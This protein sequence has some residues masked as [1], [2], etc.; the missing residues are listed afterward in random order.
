M[1]LFGDLGSG[2]CFTVLD[3]TPLNW[4]SDGFNTILE[5]SECAQSTFFNDGGGT[6]D[7]DAAN[8]NDTRYL[9]AND[10]RG[11]LR[12]QCLVRRPPV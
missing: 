5:Y 10:V 2:E 9:A 1:N 8:F 3:D 6:H 11:L 12:T 7:E 4:I